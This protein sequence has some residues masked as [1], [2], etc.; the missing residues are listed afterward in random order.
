MNSRALAAQVLV[1]VIGEGKSFHPQLI[2][3]T[4]P[5]I[6][7]E[8]KAFVAH[9]CFGVLRF[10]QRLDGWARQLIK[11]PLKKKDLDLHLLILTGLYQ[12][13]YTD[14]PPYAALHS[15]V[16]ATQSLQK[17]WAKKFVNGVLRQASL[18][19]NTLSPQD[20]LPIRTAHPTWLVKLFQQAWPDQWESII[21]AHLQ[22]PPLSLRVNQRKTQLT[23][24]LQQL[25]DQAIAATPMDFCSAG[26]QLS[27]GLAVTDLPGFTAGWISVQDGA[28]Q[29]AASL[30]D[31]KAHQRVLDACAAPGSKTAHLLETEPALAYV[32]ALDAE[33][34]RIDLLQSTLRR[35]NLTAEVQC[36]DATCPQAWWDGELFDRILLDAPCSATGVIRRHPDIKIHRQPDDIAVLAQKQK[37][38]LDALW[39]LLKPGG[40]LLYATCSILPVENVGQMLTFLHQHTDAEEWPILENWGT[41]Q[42]VGR[43]ILPG[44][45]NMDGFYYARLQKKK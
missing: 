30:L 31:L 27:E 29:L 7:N 10:Y 22:P 3:D 9:L 33:P 35:L 6:K 20:P 44:Q 5:A 43:Q 18:K 16:E 34:H 36:Q 17:A 39:P 4:F 21:A 37:L 24:Y 23:D 1:K 41:S 45:H 15:T 11:T 32:L 38:L 28:G 40:I 13:Y 2:Q 19:K 8:D 25:S 42:K 26:I 12:L 14:T